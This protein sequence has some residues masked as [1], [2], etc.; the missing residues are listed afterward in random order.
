MPSITPF[1]LSERYADHVL[2]CLARS[3]AESGRTYP[4][5][6][7]LRRTTD[8]LLFALPPQ[9]HC[10]ELVRTY[11]TSFASLFH[12]LHDPTFYQQYDSFLQ[13]PESMP[14]AW[15]ALLYAMLGTAVLALPCDS[16]ILLDLSR[17]S[18]AP[19]R[20]A[21]L[22]ERYRSLALRCLEADHFLWDHNITTLQ[23]LILIIYGISHSHGDAWSL[24]GL[25][26]HLALSIGCHVEPSA[27]G[28]DVIETEE[29]RR[30]WAGL[31]MLYTSQNTAMGHIGLA[32]TLLPS[33]C[34]P[35]ADVNDDDLLPGQVEPVSSLMKAT[36]MSYL[37]LKFRLYDICSE[38]CTRVLIK[39]DVD[40]SVIESIDASI[41]NEQRT[42]RVR[43]MDGVG[44][45]QLPSDQ[46]AHLRILESYAYHLIL[47]LHDNNAVKTGLAWSRSRCLNSAKHI[48]HIHAELQECPDYAPFRWYN[49]GLG[50]FHAFH[51]AVV[52]TT[53]LRT[54]KSTLDDFEKVVQLLR[55]C[56][57][58]FRALSELSPLC[59]RAGPM[60]EPLL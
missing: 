50:S 59:A 26:H 58:R 14:T 24:L 37:L 2:F 29:R 33:N 27:F 6:S 54:L 16:Y 7:G 19:A 44:S 5:D 11:F 3:T 31:T 15:L 60:M 47:L 51:A 4:L 43:Y 56:L 35:P 10:T 53:L 34:R 8:D 39:K 55:Q 40:L 17:G 23:A 32:H 48:L 41:Q 42:W 13:A 38:I 20:A 28:L 30:C 1:A 9:G 36:Q 45:G 49:H 12:I 22:S 57:V 25:T 21:S 18:G 46:R 52:L